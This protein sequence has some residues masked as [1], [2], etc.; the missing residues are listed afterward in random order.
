MT[1][2]CLNRKV[3][4]NLSR[5]L[6]DYTK[7]EETA[8]MITH[9]FGGVFALFT[10]LMC[11]VFAAWN[12]NV[13]GVISGIFYGISMMV[14]YVIS[15]V[16]HGL[17]PERAYKEKV[18]LR[19]VDH[20]DIYGLIVG[21]FAPIAMTGLREVSP[22]TAWVSFGLVC[23]TAVVGVVFTAIDFSK[24]KVISYGAY[25]VAG[26]S[27]I[28]TLKHLLDAFPKEFIILLLVGGAVYTLGMIFYALEKKGVH[29]AH[30]VFHLFILA[31]S[32]IHFIAV[33]K[34]C[35]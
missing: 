20:C 27:V 6:P 25:F 28:F 11:T 24:F 33:F 10:L 1:E 3:N 29:Y 13:S 32:V 12:K 18:T 5:S 31:G 2:A 8:N 35:I 34:Y 19:V 23:L 16:Y 22:V 21:T 4:T 14:V 7:N 17:D 9:I 30:S 15:S 26:W